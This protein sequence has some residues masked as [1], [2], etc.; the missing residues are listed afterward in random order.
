M[1]AIRSTEPGVFEYQLDAACRYVF[2]L[3]D[4]RL[5][6]YRSITAS[7]HR[8]HLERPLLQ[9][10]ARSSRPATWC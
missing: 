6:G 10:H 4:A 2:L 9:E 3:N 5:D 7:G 8:E 1:E